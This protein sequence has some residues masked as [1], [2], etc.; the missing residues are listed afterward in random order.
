MTM[1]QFLSTFCFLLILCLCLSGQ[2]DQINLIKD[3]YDSSLQKIID[4]QKKIRLLH[5][6]LKK[7]YPVAILEEGT[8]YLFDI[9][10][11]PKRYEFVKSAPSSFEAPQGLR[12]A[13][14]LDFYDNKTA[15]VVTGDVFDDL[16]GYV[17]IFHEFIHCAQAENGE[18]EL[19]SALGV[20]T[21]V[22]EEEDYSWELNHPF[23]YEDSGFVDIYS[24]FLEKAAASDAKGVSRCR[25]FLKETL[26]SH[27]YEYLVWQEWKEG[28][29]RMIENRIR[30]KLDLEENLGGIEKPF[31]RVTLYQGGA[32]FISVLISQDKK[33]ENDIQALFH[34]MLDGISP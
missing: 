33:L 6:F 31:N 19:K 26:N 8:F 12:A 27:D 2:T 29:A 30:K 34:R 22:W 9:N 10:S 1:R 32:L 15:C 18:Q 13:F 24:I 11:S 21:K 16:S 23:P 3:K 7:L 20:A 4:I 28:M 25:A 14:P 5:P 17:L